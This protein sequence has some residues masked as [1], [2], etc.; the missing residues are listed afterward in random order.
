L[1]RSPFFRRQIDDLGARQ[2]P[3]P[4]QFLPPGQFGLGLLFGFL[5]LNVLRR[6]LDR[7]RFGSLLTFTLLVAFGE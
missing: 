7:L 3:A 6:A 5:A 2:L 4:G 1:P